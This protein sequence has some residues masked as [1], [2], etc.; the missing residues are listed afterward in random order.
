MDIGIQV[1]V[2]VLQAVLVAVIIIVLQVLEVQA[3]NPHNQEIPEHMALEIQVVQ[4]LLTISV[5]AAV[6]QVEPAK[7]QVQMAVTAV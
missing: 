4:V 7:M 2:Q 3:Y 5:A 6:A 1:M